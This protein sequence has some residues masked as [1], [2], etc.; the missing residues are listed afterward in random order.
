MNNNKYISTLLIQELLFT[1]ISFLS[2]Q[3]FINLKL[4]SKK[5]Y[6]LIK[7]YDDCVYKKYI[8]NISLYNSEIVEIIRNKPAGSLKLSLEKNNILY[9]QFR[10]HEYKIGVNENIDNLP[11]YYIRIQYFHISF[12]YNGYHQI[13]LKSSEYYDDECG[14]ESTTII[15]LHKQFGFTEKIIFDE[16]VES[17]CHCN[18]GCK[19]IE[20][21]EHIQKYI[22][23][24]NV[25]IKDYFLWDYSMSNYIKNNN[26]IQNIE[27]ITFMEDFMEEEFDVYR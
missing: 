10:I 11:L 7:G 13:K 3:D 6:N 21:F 16:Y 15:L 25:I 9:E 5:L 26:K 19:Q 18:H 23:R 24:I 20:E 17:S 14:L 2:H 27:D 8:K 4:T 12:Y 22:P 1:I